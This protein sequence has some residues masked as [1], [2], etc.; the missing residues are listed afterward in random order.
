LDEFLRPGTSRQEEV[1]ESRIVQQALGHRFFQE[2][3]AGDGVSAAGLQDINQG[4]RP[5]LQLAAQSPL[6]AIRFDQG[7]Q[8]EENDQQQDGG[9]QSRPGQGKSGRLT[10]GA[11]HIR[12]GS[13]RGA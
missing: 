9:Q 2:G 8:A 7:V 5:I 13:M 1:D 12:S 6:E 4:H 3:V 11:R 10:D